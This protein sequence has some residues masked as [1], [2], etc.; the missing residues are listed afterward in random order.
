VRF[1]GALGRERE[2]DRGEKERGRE[3]VRCKEPALPI[4]TSTCHG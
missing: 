4:A 1:T 3:K 2:E